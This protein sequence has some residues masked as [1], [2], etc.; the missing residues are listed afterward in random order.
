MK[1]PRLSNFGP[2]SLGRAPRLR[3]HADGHTAPPL[4][5]SGVIPSG[6]ACCCA[7]GLPPGCAFDAETCASQFGGTVCSD[8][9]PE[10]KGFCC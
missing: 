7:P 6:Q 9:P 5:P 1:L 2:S 4:A 10:C 3:C 8:C